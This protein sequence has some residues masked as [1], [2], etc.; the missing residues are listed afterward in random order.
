MKNVFKTKTIAVIAFVGLMLFSDIFCGGELFGAINAGDV[1]KVLK[2]LKQGYDVNELAYGGTPLHEAARQNLPVV[3]HLLVDHGA[4]PNKFAGGLGGGGKPLHFAAQVGADA[5]AR[6]LISRG[7]DINV[8]DALNRTPLVYALQSSG[9]PIG[10]ERI[11]LMLT[12]RGAVL[13]PSRYYDSILHQ[14]AKHGYADL[15]RVLIK[16]GVSVGARNTSGETPLHFAAS[17]GF[18]EMIRLLLHRGANPNAQ[19]RKQE[20]PLHYAARSSRA[21]EVA[22]VL[23]RK[24]AKLRA[25]DSN[26]Q[27][28]LH[29]AVSEGAQNVTGLMNAINALKNG[30]AAIC[31]LLRASDYRGDSPLGLAIRIA[32]ETGDVE[33]SANVTLAMLSAIPP[34]AFVRELPLILRHKDPRKNMSP[35]LKERLY[36]D[37]I[38]IAFLGLP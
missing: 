8:S 25:V 2:L 13:Q 32:K 22:S 33:R 38:G 31:D 14:A 30:P 4:N 10:S 37:P 28:L 9:N 12:E 29:L 19:N 26:R 15:A 1:A 27:N 3:V 23:L 6:A 18:P 34:D 24:G 16:K 21:G 35:A 17:S 20:T 11:A 36:Q 5:A 7:A